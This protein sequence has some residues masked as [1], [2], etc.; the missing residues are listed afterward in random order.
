MPWI[1]QCHGSPRRHMPP[2]FTTKHFGEWVRWSC[3]PVSSFLPYLY[4][5]FYCGVY[6]LHISTISLF[7]VVKMEFLKMSGFTWKIMMTES[8]RPVW[9][10]SFCCTQL[11]NLNATGYDYPTNRRYDRKFS[12]D[13]VEV[14]KWAMEK[15]ALACFGCIQGGPGSSYK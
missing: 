15:R 2:G 9:P 14:D 10:S 5:C 13:T 3:Q 8:E 4:M 1:S 7:L 12:K 11:R 6:C